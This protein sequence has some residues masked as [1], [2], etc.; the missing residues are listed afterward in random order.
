M[1]KTRMTLD[2]LVQAIGWTT[3][4]AEDADALT[5][6]EYNHTHSAILIPRVLRGRIAAALRMILETS[7]EPLLTPMDQKLFV[8]KYCSSKTLQAARRAIEEESARTGSAVTYDRITELLLST[9]NPSLEE[10]NV[11]MEKLQRLQE[12][13]EQEQ[14][15][16]QGGSV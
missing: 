2:E 13:L 5:P 7:T 1:T 10:I 8:L 16:R 3:I 12:E 14:S 4:M 6:D 9:S 15:T 11:R